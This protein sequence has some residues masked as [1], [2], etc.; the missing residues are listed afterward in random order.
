MVAGKQKR[1]REGREGVQ[2]GKLR[3]LG[4]ARQGLEA[5]SESREGS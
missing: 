5:A 2:N 1:K 4:K 3:K